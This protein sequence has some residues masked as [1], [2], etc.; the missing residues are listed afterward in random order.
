MTAVPDL[1]AVEAYHAAVIAAMDEW[2]GPMWEARHLTRAL[3]DRTL[4]R[5]RR[6]Q[7]GPMPA[8]A[9]WCGPGPHPCPDALD[10]WADLTAIGSAYSQTICLNCGH[11]SPHVQQDGDECSCRCVDYKTAIGTTDRV[12]PISEVASSAVER[13]RVKALYEAARWVAAFDQDLPGFDRETCRRLAAGMKTMA[14][15][16]ATRLAA[17]PN[18]GAT[19]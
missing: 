19:P 15:S 4:D 13:A 16:A 17:K 10:A 14:N 1:A 6:H 9:V 8:H 12:N 5:L 11:D 7:P 3:A 18:S 2:Q